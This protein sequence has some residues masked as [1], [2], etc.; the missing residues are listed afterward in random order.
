VT[1]RRWTVPTLIVIALAIP[2]IADLYEMVSDRGRAVAPIDVDLIADGVLRFEGRDLLIDLRAGRTKADHAPATPSYRL[3]E[4]WS[5]PEDSGTWTLADRASLDF[6][7]MTDGQRSLMLQCR[8]D[9]RRKPPPI[10][11]VTEVDFDEIVARR[12]PVVRTSKAAVRVHAPGTLFLEFDVPRPDAMVEFHCGYPRAVR[13]AG[14]DVVVGRWF[15]DKNALDAVGRVRVTGDRGRSRSYRIS[16][17]NH[18]GPSLLRIIV[19]ETSAEA[20]LE[21][22]SPRLVAY[23]P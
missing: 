19:D 10:L 14:C 15:P 13:G 1:L 2:V 17:G 16:L 11:R 6:R 4:D 23:G 9:R 12:P 21:L 22:R 20:G 5:A 18:S 3:G 7:V 8:P